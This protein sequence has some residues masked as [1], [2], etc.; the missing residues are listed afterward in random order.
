MD[1]VFPES[2]TGSNPSKSRQN[3]VRTWNPKGLLGQKEAMK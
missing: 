1:F 3:A 2:E